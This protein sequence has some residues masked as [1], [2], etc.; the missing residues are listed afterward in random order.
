MKRIVVG[1]GA[2]LVSC[3]TAWGQGTPLSSAAP[4][5]RPAV[6]PSIVAPSIKAAASKAAA[7]APIQP[8]SPAQKPDPGAAYYHFMLAR[9]AE[10][11]AEL[12]GGGP[13]VARALHE[14]HLAL[15]SD[16]KSGYIPE[17]M[18]ELL[19][20]SGRTG[21]ALRLARSVE[22]E[23]PGD[24]AVHRFLGEVYAYMLGGGD[25]A[26]KSAPSR[27]GKLAIDEYQSLT[28]LRPLESDNYSTLGKLY[29]AN[30]DLP[31]AEQAFERALQLSPGNAS[32][33]R[34]LVYVETELGHSS[35]AQALLKQLSMSDKTPGLYTALGQVYARQHLWTRALQSYQ[36]GLTLQPGDVDL[37][38]GLA[39]TQ[40]Q[41]GDLDGARNT[42]QK[43]TA[44][45]TQDAESFVQL[46]RVQK[47]LGDF[48]GAGKSLARAQQLAPDDPEVA[49]EVASLA[50][51]QG[52]TARAEALL[53]KLIQANTRA[54][55][56]YSL[57]EASNLGVFLE[58]LGRVQAQSGDVTGA[59][60]S[61]AQLRQL[62]RDNAERAIGEQVDLYRA[63]HQMPQALQAAAEGVKLAPQSL[64]LRTSYALALADNGQWQQAL[65][66]AALMQSKAA[67]QR[68]ALLR[69]QIY[70]RGRQ[71]KAAT[72][73]A[74]QALAAAQVTEDKV[75]AWFMLGEVAEQQKHYGPAEQDFQQALRLSPHEGTA[76]NYLAYIL[77]ERNTRLPEALRDAHAAVSLEPTNGAYLD[78][79]GWIELKLKDLKNAVPQLERAAALRSH[80][81]VILEHLGDAYFQS[82]Q[83]RQA[84]VQWTRAL[85]EW[86][87]AAVADYDKK[88]VKRVGKQ[89]HK[90]ETQLAKR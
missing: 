53:G 8:G 22:Q 64:S 11:R 46:A 39:R 80:D 52:D 25:S 68:L 23:H 32:T 66:Q 18:A 63:Q 51:S 33:I 69:A 12:A 65:Q 43:L 30:H 14:Y 77:A 47:A 36:Q 71:W 9:Q 73:A 20:R 6:A 62:G 57:A 34:N 67:P 35:R 48:P 17:Q 2:V 29:R 90:V 76:L 41:V 37:L 3:L 19:F 82:G 59:Q 13:E 55:G 60:K 21:D 1:T 70:E 88:A 45:D 78:T 49:Y 86:K 15:H 79:L 50:A 26:S 40:L 58:K 10:E 72:R 85:N 27:L 54:D 61:F 24:V 28:R 31:R 83:L 7:S 4:A 5:S 75:D 89:L 44:T 42:Y 16:P 74:Q 87:T 84:Q 56:R 81:P 38:R